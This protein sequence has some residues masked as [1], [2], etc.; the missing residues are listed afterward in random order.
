MTITET[1]QMMLANFNPDAASGLYKTI[2]WVISGN[3]AGVWAFK[4]S[5]QTCELIPGGVERPNMTLSV[6]DMDWLDIVEGR[7]DAMVAFA[8][9]KV[10]MKGEIMLGMRIHKLFPTVG[11]A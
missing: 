8:T 1:F 11:N 4:I 9:G 2:Q 10:K 3:E 7:L 6:S 5:N